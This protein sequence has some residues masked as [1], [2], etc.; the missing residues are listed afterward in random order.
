MHTPPTRGD[1]RLAIQGREIVGNLQPFATC[2]AHK[3][4]AHCA[5]TVLRG[6]QHTCIVQPESCCVRCLAAVPGSGLQHSSHLLTALPCI[7]KQPGRYALQD[8]SQWGR[9]LTCKARCLATCCSIACC[10]LQPRYTR[11]G[12]RTHDGTNPKVVDLQG[13]ASYQCANRAVKW[14][15]LILNTTCRQTCTCTC[16]TA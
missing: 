2:T 13:E 12:A 10:A 6:Q 8:V 7:T 3:H 1:L 9:H 5:A 16:R 15:Q 14:I 11:R 4:A